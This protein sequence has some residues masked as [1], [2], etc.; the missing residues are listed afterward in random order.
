MKTAD[1]VVLYAAIGAILVVLFQPTGRK[2]AEVVDQALDLMS[3][4]MEELKREQA[5]G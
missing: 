5:S 2:T 1:L 4:R 3:Q